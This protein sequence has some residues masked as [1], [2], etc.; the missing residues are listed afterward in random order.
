MM[1]VL[2]YIFRFEG[3]VSVLS[4][5]DS[6][7]LCTESRPGGACGQFPMDADGNID[8]QHRLR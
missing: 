4:A 5:H 2:R 7:R 6:P 8:L 3:D 1:H